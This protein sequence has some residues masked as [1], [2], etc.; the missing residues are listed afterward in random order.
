MR[1]IKGFVVAAVPKNFLS[2]KNREV[3]LFGSGKRE[4][5]F[6]M[7]GWEKEG[8]MVFNEPSESLEVI[9][10]LTE[11]KMYKYMF[12]VRVEMKI[13]ERGEN[14]SISDE[15]GSFVLIYSPLPNQRRILGPNTHF[16]SEAFNGRVGF[17]TGNKLKTFRYF[18]EVA[19]L[20]DVLLEEKNNVLVA[21]LRIFD[22]SGKEMTKPMEAGKVMIC[23]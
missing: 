9:S 16:S 19:E 11:S 17:F 20:R 5:K 7:F 2:G 4:K 21:S 23:E 18:S 10:C 14:F 15:G 3:I 1:E 12:P 6:L 8:F 22:L 13:S